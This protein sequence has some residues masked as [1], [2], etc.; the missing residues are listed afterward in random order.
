MPWVTRFV[1]RSSELA[2]LEREHRR[3]AA[4]EF[5]SVLLLSDPGIG[6]TRLAHEFLARRHRGAITLSARAYPLGETAAFCVWSEALERHLRGLDA[7]DVS[8]LCGGFLDDLA[9]VIRSVAARP[10]GDRCLEP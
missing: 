4:G 9:A 6:K 2:E 10:G 7:Q 3:A 5:R 1:G 8:Q